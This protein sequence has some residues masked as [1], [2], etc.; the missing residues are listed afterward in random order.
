MKEIRTDAEKHPIYYLLITV[1]FTV[2]FISL[3]LNKLFEKIIESERLSFYISNVI[4]RVVL[5]VILIIFAKKLKL[6]LINKISGIKFL[7]PLFVALIISVNNFPIIGVINKNVTF[8]FSV[9]ELVFYVVYCFFVA[10]IEELAFRGIVLPL[11]YV[12]FKNKKRGVVLTVFFSSLVFGLTH[13]LN[14]FGGASILSTLLQVGYSFLI[15]SMCA[16]VFIATKNISFAVLIHFVFDIGGL[17]LNK[18]GIAS[19]NQWDIVT[20]IITCVL[21]VI[22]LV[23]FVIYLFKCKNEELNVF[24]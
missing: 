20:V 7:L 24:M 17:L 22:A 16:A 21:G 23:Y 12:K 13:L 14:L 1:L 6:K 4:L 11:F 18:R 10:F 8:D 5:A 19:G 2:G 15:G 3:P 9:L